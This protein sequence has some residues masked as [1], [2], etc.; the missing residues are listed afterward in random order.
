MTHPKWWTL[1]ATTTPHHSG[2]TA[3]PG[4]VV[5]SLLQSWHRGR[6]PT[7]IPNFR[8]LDMVWVAIH[9]GHRQSKWGI[10]RCTFEGW[11]HVRDHSGGAGSGSLVLGDD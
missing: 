6:F 10:W 4:L 1:P 5:G 11:A 9:D 7:S 2:Q 8:G 3:P